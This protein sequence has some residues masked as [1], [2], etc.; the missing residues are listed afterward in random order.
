M[1]NP[2]TLISQ[3][4][5]ATKLLCVAT[6]MLIS[7]VYTNDVLAQI[8]QTSNLS[9]LETL[10]RNIV[11]FLTGT[12]GTGIATIAII[13]LA[14]LALSGRIQMSTAITIAAGIILIFLSVNIAKFFGAGTPVTL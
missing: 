7:F 13:A 1:K 8:G 11:T 6:V 14:F 9:G 5:N 2:N 3:F 10:V 12:F 4:P